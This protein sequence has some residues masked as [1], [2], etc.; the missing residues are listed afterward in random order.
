MLATP[1]S[2]EISKSEKRSCK[3]VA[4][5]QPKESSTPDII[6]SITPV[7]ATNGE[8]TDR[9]LEAAL[10]VSQE[11]MESLTLRETDLVPLQSEKAGFTFKEPAE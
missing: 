4:K 10:Q 9:D 7:E 5:K 1:V 11:Q 8:I 6:V 3:V 2:Q